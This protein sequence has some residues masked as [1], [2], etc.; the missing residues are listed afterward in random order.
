M[1]TAGR[2]FTLFWA[3]GFASEGNKAWQL[4]FKLWLELSN[5]KIAYLIFF[6]LLLIYP[7]QE[8]KSASFENDTGVLHLLH[9]HSNKFHI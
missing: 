4:S 5:E 2:I 1:S 6:I 9:K 3:T 8:Q 7:L